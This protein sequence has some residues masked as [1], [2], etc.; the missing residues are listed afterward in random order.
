MDYISERIYFGEIP[1]DT[2]E[3]LDRESIENWFDAELNFLPKLTRFKMAK[4]PAKMAYEVTTIVKCE[5]TGNEK[6]SD[7]VIFD[8]IRNKTPVIRKTYAHVV[9]VTK[10]NETWVILGTLLSTT[11]EKF[12][13]TQYCITFENLQI[14]ET[15]LLFRNCSVLSIQDYYV[16][17]GC[18]CSPTDKDAKLGER[19]LERFNSFELGQDLVF[20]SGY[21]PFVF[22]WMLFLVSASDYYTEKFIEFECKQF[23]RRLDDLKHNPLLQ[24][25]Y[26]RKW[27]RWD[28]TLLPMETYRY[29]DNIEFVDFNSEVDFVDKHSRDHYSDAPS[30]MMRID[31]NMA[32]WQRPSVRCIQCRKYDCQKCPVSEG[33][34]LVPIQITPFLAVHALRKRL[35]D[36]V[37]YYRRHFNTRYAYDVWPTLGLQ[38]TIEEIDKHVRDIFAVAGHSKRKNVDDVVEQFIRTEAKRMEEVQLFTELDYLILV[39]VVFPLWKRMI[40]TSSEDYEPIPNKTDAKTPTIMGPPTG[41]AQVYTFEH[42]TTK[43]QFDEEF[44]KPPCI[45][46]MLEKCVGHTHIDNEA[47]VRMF[48]SIAAK[49][50]TDETARRL[51]LFLFQDTDVFKKTC[52]GN[53]DDFW[54]HDIGLSFMYILTKYSKNSPTCKTF[55]QHGLC[56]HSGGDIEDLVKTATESCT[57]LTNTRRIAKGRPPL[58]AKF[59]IWSPNMMIEKCV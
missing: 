59:Q 18:P 27:L 42:I 45:R 56:V 4:T 41:R 37:E 25:E 14:R 34:V 33:K 10:I 36:N 8:F 17:S 52:N 12:M 39:R 48:R 3:R 30:H 51:C 46:K 13:D 57:N 38:P 16:L 32:P 20:W 35:R 29:A 28:L 15:S 11:F 44:S 2:L 5:F 22:H 53:P 49:S 43:E 55:I 58:P 26:A 23:S 31:I 47:R 7:T 21:E 6:L 50:T 19:L 24:F 9:F 1:V 40:D 54:K